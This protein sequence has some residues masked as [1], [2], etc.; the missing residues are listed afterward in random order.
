MLRKRKL[1]DFLFDFHPPGVA[2]YNRDRT[3]GPFGARLQ[4]NGKM[5]YLGTFKKEEDAARAYDQ[6][7]IK[8]FKV[9]E[10]FP[11]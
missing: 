6:A 10:I 5:M 8:Y 11:F 1:V 4:V 3:R 2:Y 7:V 9:R